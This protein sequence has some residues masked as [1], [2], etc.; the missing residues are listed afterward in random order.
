MRRYVLIVFIVVICLS[1]VSFAFGAFRA[2]FIPFVKIDKGPVHG[3]YGKSLSG[4][5]F[6][7]ENG[8]ITYRFLNGS[9]ERVGLKESVSDLEVSLKPAGVSSSITIYKGGADYRKKTLKSFS[10]LHVG[11]I[12]RSI[13]LRL[14][15]RE[16]SL[17]KVFTVEPGGKVSDIHVRVDGLLDLKINADGSLALKTRN[18][19][20]LFTKPVAYQRVDDRKVFVDVSYR[21]FPDGYGFSVGEYDPSRELIIDPLLA[22]TFL[23]TPDGISVEDMKI[24]KQTGNVYVAGYFRLTDFGFDFPLGTF[25]LNPLGGGF[26]DFIGSFVAEFNNDLT[27]LI[28][29]AIL[30]GSSM[31]EAL[32]IDEEGNVFVTGEAKGEIPISGNAYRKSCYKLG[33]MYM[34]IMKLSPSLNQLIYSTGFCGYDDYS[35]FGVNDI[36]LSKEGDV[37][38]LGWSGS[39]RLPVTI[40]AYDKTY[41]D[42]GSF[43][44]GDVFIV[45]FNPDLSRLLTSTYLGGDNEDVPVSL[46][47]YN[48]KVFVMGYTASYKFPVT[49]GALSKEPDDSSISRDVFISVFDKD[50]SKLEASARL[51]GS[52]DDIP[53][54][55]VISS[56]GGIYIVGGTSSGDFMRVSGGYEPQKPP[57]SW[58]SGFIVKVHSSLSSEIFFSYFDVPLNSVA[59]SDSSGDVYVAGVTCEKLNE[60]VLPSRGYGGSCDAFVARLNPFLNS[61]LSFTYLGGSENEDRPKIALDG[62]DNVFVMGY[63]RSLDFPVTEGAYSTTPSGA[64]LSKFDPLLSV[65]LA[66]L[67]NITLIPVTP[68]NPFTP[69]PFNPIQLNAVPHISSLSATPQS[70]TAPLEVSFRCE[71]YD[72]DGSIVQYRWDF[73]GNGN[74]DIITATDKVTFTYLK[75][76]LYHAR[77]RV[78]D[79]DG[80][81]VSEDIT[82]TVAQPASDN[83]TPFSYDRF[84][85][86]FPLQGSFSMDKNGALYVGDKEGALISIRGSA[87]RSNTSLSFEPVDVSLG[88]DGS[89]YIA[90]S[91]GVSKLSSSKEKQWEYHVRGK[92]FSSVAVGENGEVY[93]AD[94]K[95]YLY[96]LN[97]EG[98]EIFERKL[99]ASV[100]SPVVLD[101]E[102]LYVGDTDGYLYRFDRDGNLLWKVRLSN[103]YAMV[104]SPAIYGNSVYVASGEGVLYRISQ[105]GSLMWNYKFAASLSGSS[106]IIDLDGVVYIGV[107]DGCIYAILPEGNLK[108]KFCT[109]GPIH[110]TPTLTKEGLILVGSDDGYLYALDRRDG[111]LEW[112]FKASGSVRGAPMVDGNGNVWFASI[113]GYIYRLNDVC[114]SYATGA[115]PRLHRDNRNSSNL[116]PFSDISNDGYLWAFDSIVSLYSHGITEGYPG[117]EYRPERDVSRAEMAVYLARM[118][119]LSV[120]GC[121]QAPFSD[122]SSGEWSCPYI[123]AIKNAGIT[124]GYPDNSYKPSAP[125]KRLEMAVFLTRALGLSPVECSS[126]PFSDV[127]E[128][129]WYCKYVNAIKSAG[130]TTGYPDG[131]YKPQKHVTRAEMAVYIMRGLGLK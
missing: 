60:P 88:L 119:G 93:M 30:E 19:N 36:A 117:G 12:G 109:A 82:V 59:V 129:A 54:R 3:F 79:N 130:I 107:T 25:Y 28:S 39:D 16:N 34:F 108:W 90:Y 94:D 91:E 84:H 71:A 46:A 77:C 26:H 128:D 8:E 62:D 29:C 124:T 75:K 5:F 42:N 14:V 101:R 21:L 86:N 78:V 98:E 69:A 76:G 110:S 111:T 49:P 70:G 85:I 74:V 55:M 27:R 17:E 102:S 2:P 11:K 53:Y 73:D 104:S 89:I 125:V 64:F 33:N 4:S 15:L 7:S 18:G 56:M 38:V 44:W 95:G 100:V 96:A 23:A 87:V 52:E 80:A 50:L 40:N 22:S 63:T 122:V 24:N 61:L 127:P 126:P 114:D 113:D 123:A 51:G 68:Y 116:V 32:A 31:M 120:S 112:K 58:Y 6:V 121:A 105:D 48:N 10:Q 35:I 72:P 106:P 97:P 37:Y 20:A 118:L 92:L 103:L 83:S 57:S 1:T 47:V 66:P 43:P 65:E 81:F 9:G 13:K 99:E 45:K 131:T 41:N 67:G 115:W